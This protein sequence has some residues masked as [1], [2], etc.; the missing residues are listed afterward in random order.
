MLYWTDW[1]RANPKI[2]RSWLDGS[3]REVLVSDVGLPNGLTI[4]YQSRQLCWA[5]AGM[6]QVVFVVAL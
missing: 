1:D 4:D 6:L 2:E 5:D 3:N